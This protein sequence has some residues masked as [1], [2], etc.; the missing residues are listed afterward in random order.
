MCRTVTKRDYGLEIVVETSRLPDYQRAKAYAIA[1]L[2]HDLSPA[3]LYHSLWHT[4]D[5]VAPRAEWLAKVEG[6]SQEAQVL[7]GTAAYFHDIGFTRQVKNH[8]KVSAQV[9]AEVLPH[10]GYTPSQIRLVASII[11]ATRIPQSAR[12]LLH[13]VVADADLD[14]LGRKDFVERNAALQAEVTALGV[15]A[16][17]EIWYPNQVRFLKLHRYFTA[18]ARNQRSLGKQENLRTIQAIIAECCPQAQEVLKAT[19]APSFAR[20]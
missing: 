4:C 12:S 17:D 13:Q 5:E 11:M 10:F 14:V 6:L 7:V 19:P 15:A 18:T 9:A 20:P 3:L 8:E 1:R 2:E 16:P